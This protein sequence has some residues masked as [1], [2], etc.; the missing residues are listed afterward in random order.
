[1]LSCGMKM[2]WIEISKSPA[3]SNPWLKV[4][5]QDESAPNKKKVERIEAKELMDSEACRVLVEML[6]LKKP[7]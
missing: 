6:D 3:F 2:F 1:M 7:A 5:F 4:T